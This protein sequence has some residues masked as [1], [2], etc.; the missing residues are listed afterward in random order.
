MHSTRQ[1]SRNDSWWR[2][3]W[4]M[5]TSS[6]SVA[7]Q[8]PSGKTSFSILLCSRTRC[9]RPSTALVPLGDVL[10]IW[11]HICCQKSPLNFMASRCFIDWSE[12]LLGFGAGGNKTN[13]NTLMM[14]VSSSSTCERKTIL[15]ANSHLFL[16]VKI[17]WMGI[18]KAVAVT[19]F[20]CYRETSLLWWCLFDSV[21]LL[22][23]RPFVPEPRLIVWVRLEV[24]YIVGPQ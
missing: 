20:E 13:S 23:V 24:R 10:F 18:G 5:C 9:Q 7:G 2:V 16:R 15:L 14:R 11:S 21:V 17:A 8:M 4:F 22:I 3:S 1:H 6:D 12:R 19:L